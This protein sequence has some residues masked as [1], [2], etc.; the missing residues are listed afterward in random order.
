MKFSTCTYSIAAPVA[1]A[2]ACRGA[3][4]AGHSCRRGLVAPSLLLWQT[5]SSAPASLVCLRSTPQALGNRRP[6]PSFSMLSRRTLFHTPSPRLLPRVPR[7]SRPPRPNAIQQHR[8]RFVI[9]VLRNQFPAKRFFEDGLPQPRSPAQLEHDCSIGRIRFSS[10]LSPQIIRSINFSSGTFFFRSSGWLSFLQL[11]VTPTASTSTKCVFAVASCVT[12]IK[13]SGV[14]GRKFP[15]PS[16]QFLSDKFPQSRRRSRSGG[17]TE[18]GNLRG[19][20]RCRGI[21]SLSKSCVGYRSERKNSPG[22]PSKKSSPAAERTLGVRA[23][24]G[25]SY[26]DPTPIRRVSAAVYRAPG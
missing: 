26:A 19:I 7:L 20:A 23:P 4:W 10:V 24:R 17:G 22:R 16:K 1:H 12:L 11:S 18:R 14:T 5:P 25:R 13:S 15:P 21:P 3:V 6:V 2:V 9:R 8:S